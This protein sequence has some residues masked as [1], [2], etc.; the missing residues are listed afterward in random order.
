M[1]MHDTDIQHPP[2]SPVPAPSGS[3]PQPARPPRPIRPDDKQAV[4]RLAE[5]AFPPTQAA[6]VQAGEEGFVIDADQG[7]AAAVIVRAVPIPGGRRVGFVTWAMTD[8]DHRGRGHASVLAERGVARLA[9]LGC[10]GILTEIEGH[11][12]A[13]QAV[14]RGLGFRPIGLKDQIAALG[15]SGAV[16]FRLR[17]GYTLDPGHF[18][19]LQGA[20]SETKAEMPERLVAWGLNGL[21]ALI[22]LSLGG[23]LL[24]QGA[25]GLP[26]V[27]ESALLLAAVVFV[28]GAREA[29]MRVAAGARGVPVVF[30]AWD[31]GLSI[32]AVIAL[33]FGRLFPLPGSVYPRQ[34]G[35]RYAETLP[36]LATA[37][38]AGVAAIA[39]IVA[40]AAWAA[41]AHAGTPAGAFAGSV[42]L[43]GKPLLLFDT[44]MAFPPFQA[45][46]ARRIYDF[47]RGLWAGVAALGLVLF[48]L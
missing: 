2:H 48:L 43:I 25:P 20:A 8:P 47:H 22:V 40:G 13:S 16:S 6:F 30:R 12:T 19:W 28:L 45:F 38:L 44:V 1:A 37:A 39:A 14:F 15:L 10:D 23:G 17:S 9:E 35:W 18:L 27:A 3:R 42:L 31:S 11:N 4:A 5:R 46:N 29:A 32:T 7:L 34:A 33:L 36:A 41:A 21:F 26:S 24:L